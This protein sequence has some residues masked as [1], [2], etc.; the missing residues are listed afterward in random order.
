MRACSFAAVITLMLIS[1]AA[2]AQTIRF[3]G[4]LDFDITSLPA[5][6]TSPCFFGNLRTPGALEHFGNDIM[7]FHADIDSAACGCEGGWMVTSIHLLLAN[8]SSGPTTISGLLCVDGQGWGTYPSGCPEANPGYWGE[9]FDTDFGITL[10][11]PGYYELIVS[12]SS[13]CAFFGYE[14]FLEIWSGEESVRLVVDADGARECEALGAIHMG[15]RWWWYDP[16]Y[17]QFSPWQMTSGAPV[18]WV[19]AGCCETPVA[20]ERKSWGAVKAL[21]R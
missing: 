9:L 19:E 14:Y 4:G 13:P 5:S 8:V 3:L 7:S 18:W 11:E 21:F 2:N 16:H 17:Q 20:S 6:P 1:A 10:Q 12:G 15:E